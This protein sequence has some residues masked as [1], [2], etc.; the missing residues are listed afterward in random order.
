MFEQIADSI[1]I[2]DK[3]NLGEEFGNSIYVVVSNY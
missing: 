1:V 2:I 3:E